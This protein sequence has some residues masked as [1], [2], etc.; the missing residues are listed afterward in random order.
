MP[1]FLFTDIEGSTRLWESHRDLMEGVLQRHDALIQQALDAYGGRLVKHLGDGTFCVFDGGDPLGCVLAIQQAFVAEPWPEATGPIRIRAGL[2]LGETQMR[3]GDYFG[4]TIN[5]TARVMDAGWGNQVLV[6]QE[7]KDDLPLPEGASLIDL[8]T[9]RLKDLN[10]PVQLYQLAHPDLPGEFPPPRSLSS[11]S[12]N[13]PVRSTPF[14][15]R[16]KAVADLVDLLSGENTRLVTLLGPGGM[17]KTRL[18]MQVGDALLDTFRNGVCFVNL[19]PITEAGLVASTIAR[20]IGIREGGGRPPLENLKDYLKD[21]HL[22]LILD[23]F[24]QITDA[25]DVVAD[26]LASTTQVKML[27]TSRIPLR[28]RGEREYPLSSLALPEPGVEV[29][30]EEALLYG[31]IALFVQQAQSVKPTFTLSEENLAAVVEICRRLDGLPLALE[32]AAARIKLLSP[33]AMLKRLDQSL[34]LLVGG[35]RDLPARQQTLRGAIDWSYELLSEDERRTFVKLGVFVGGFTFE[36]ADAVCNPDGDLDILSGIEVLLNNSLIRQVDTVADEPR[37]DMLKTIREYA[38]EKQDEAGMQRELSRAH[39]AYFAQTVA[40]IDR[41]FYDS[42]ATYWLERVDEEHDNI[43]AVLTWGIDNPEGLPQAIQMTIT[44]FWFWYRYGHFH[45]GRAWAE[46]LLS[47]TEGM[48][49]SPLRTI[50]LSVA[51]MM[52]MWQG[53]LSIANE[54]M[55]EAARIMATQDDEG[56]KA[57]MEMSYGVVLLNQGRDTEAYHH[58]VEA[59]ELM[60]HAGMRWFKATTLVHLANVALGIGKPDEAKK[61]LDEATPIVES[62][63]EAWQVAFALN[64]YGEILRTQGEYAKAEDYY[65][66]TEAFYQKADARGDQARLIHTLGYIALHKGDLEEAGRLFRTSLKD[67]QDLGNKRGMAE[68]LAGLAAVAAQEGDREWSVPLLSA[69]DALLGEMGAAW[70]PADRVEVRGNRATLEAALDAARFDAL[71]AEGQTMPL[72]QA[73]AYAR[74]RG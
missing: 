42:N 52:A 74:S 6:T 68:C 64:N 4:P 24:E 9:H 65:K 53:D 19:A 27:V 48:E 31:A 50:I 23:N 13:L 14:I 71:W 25:A 47:R 46:R 45:E 8:G 15:G 20:A 1:V 43:R 59:I 49:D 12:N 63:G 55:I 3:D 37:F 57:V 66:Q 70:W 34:T 5:R 16:A 18:S 36:S 22:L 41:E 67:F 62:I 39:A 61:W 40:E 32:I 35:A 73:M 72:H 33:Q 29:N 30:V 11:R 7:V 58:L 44:M 2:H 17:G 51:G 54:R 26:L 38:L 21:K 10:E 56:I 69:A 28:L 60:D